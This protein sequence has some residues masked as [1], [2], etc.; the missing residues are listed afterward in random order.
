MTGGHRLT[1]QEILHLVHGECLARQIPGR[2]VSP[3]NSTPQIVQKRGE[4]VR[5]DLIFRTTLIRV[6][7]TNLKRLKHRAR[8]ASRIAKIAA[9]ASQAAAYRL[10]DRDVSRFLT[11]ACLD[12]SYL[13]DHS[14]TWR[15]R[16]EF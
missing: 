1:F 3:R 10:R 7:G 15:R 11:L 2:R 8:L 5:D 13:S 16:H 14:P 9:P 12:Q 4:K 6:R